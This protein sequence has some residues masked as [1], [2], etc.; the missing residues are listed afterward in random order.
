MAE[1]QNQDSAATALSGQSG[2]QQG[3]ESNGGGQ[4]AQTFDVGG[5]QVSV[6]DLKAGYLRQSDY[7]AKTQELSTQKDS[8]KQ[9]QELADY[10]KANPKLAQSIYD[11]ANK[12]TQFGDGGID[13]DIDPSQIK[14][15]QLERRTASNEQELARRD[16]NDVIDKIIGDPKYNGIFSNDQEFQ[17]AFMAVALTKTPSRATKGEVD[18]IL[19]KSADNWFKKIT[20]LKADTM[21]NAEKKVLENLNSPTRKA[22]VG[23][24][25]MATPKGIDLK[26]IKMGSRE[27]DDLGLKALRGEI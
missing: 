27:L 19:R 11:T 4:Q 17:E 15:A 16:T 2:E 5:Q 3:G 18:S 14:I 21:I 10:L 25:T 6:D 20:G 7:T 1:Q 26:G 9:T 23:A 12:H 8:L 22:T 24:G 13:G